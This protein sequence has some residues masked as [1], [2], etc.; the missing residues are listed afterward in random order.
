MADRV[1]FISWAAPIPGRE[2][3]SL[4]VFNDTVGLYGRFQ[5]DGMIESFD[6]V[7]LNAQH[8]VEGYMELRGTHEQ[9]DAVQEN[10]E[11]RRTLVDA[12]LIVENLRVAE[13]VTNEGVARDMAMYQEA[14]S[15][16]PQNA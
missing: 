2:E 16:V 14:I 9:L 11:F 6:V 13:G 12:S 15:K 1:L 5:Q 7:L 10:E 3:R 4:E 8:D